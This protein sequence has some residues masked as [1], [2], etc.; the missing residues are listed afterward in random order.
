M[1]FVTGLSISADWKN[2]SYNSILVIVNRLIKIV[3]YKLVE[4]TIDIYGLAEVIINMVVCYPG[5]PGLVVIDQ[6]L[7]FILKFK[8]LLYH[9]LGIKKK[10]FT[11]FYSQTDSQ[12][13]RQNSMIEVYFRVFIY[14]E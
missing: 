2:D 3:H 11:A 1:N 13:K 7:L 9:F 4:I 5:V 12:T 6:S 14:W 10:L 8:F